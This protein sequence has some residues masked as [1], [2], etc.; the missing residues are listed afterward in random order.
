MLSRFFP[1][2]ASLISRFSHGF[3]DADNDHDESDGQS[4][5]GQ[6]VSDRTK[7]MVPEKEGVIQGFKVEFSPANAQKVVVTFVKHQQNGTG[8]AGKIK[9]R[10]EPEI[11]L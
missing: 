9:D 4:T 1:S 3:P 2:F 5:V 6:A 7:G 8:G 11:P 10:S